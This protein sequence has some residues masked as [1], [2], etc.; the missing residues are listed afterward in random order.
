MNQAKTMKAGG[1]KSM[2]VGQGFL[3]IYLQKEKP[4]DIVHNAQ[5]PIKVQSKI[6]IIGSRRN[7]S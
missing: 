3:Q 1:N 4:T 5:N 6:P 2:S 7:V